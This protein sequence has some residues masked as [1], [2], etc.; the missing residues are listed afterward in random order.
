[1]SNNQLLCVQD[2]L[3]ITRLIEYMK[4]FSCLLMTYAYICGADT[5]HQHPVI[6]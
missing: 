5:C 6:K 1:M 2:D 3:S 4:F